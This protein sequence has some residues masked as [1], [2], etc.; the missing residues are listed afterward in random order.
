MVTIEKSDAKIAIIVDE[1]ERLV[2]TLTDGDI[3]RAIINNISTDSLAKD[4]AYTSPTT[5]CIEDSGNTEKLMKIMND[6]HN[7]SSTIA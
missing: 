7:S 2:G 1:Q 5:G 3:R 4:I 6:N